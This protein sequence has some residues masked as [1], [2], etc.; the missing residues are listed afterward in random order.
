MRHDSRRRDGAIHTSS[1]LKH[2][3][4]LEFE[5]RP[6]TSREFAIKL[7]N[8]NKKNC[9]MN[10]LIVMPAGLRDFTIEPSGKREEDEINGIYRQIL[11]ISNIMVALMKQLPGM[12]L[13]Y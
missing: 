11:S 9:L 7:V 12:V 5:A 8:Q 6:S 1:F 3:Q 13:N 2:F 4:E 10:K